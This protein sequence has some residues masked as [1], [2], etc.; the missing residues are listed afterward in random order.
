MAGGAGN[1]WRPDEYDQAFGFVADHG[2]AVL[3]LLGDV[4]GRSVLD[5]GC[6]TGHLTAAL[7]DRGASEVVGLDLSAAMLAAARRHYPALRF[8][9]GDAATMDLAELH[10]GHPFDAAFSNAALHW[11]PDLAAVCRSIHGVLASGGRFA[12]E[13]GGQGNIAAID[14]ALR[15][16]L[17]DVDLRDVE[18]PHQQFPTAAQQ[19]AL[20][21]SAGF[22]VRLLR[23]FERPTPLAPA[24]T[25]ASWTQHFRA[26]VWE[27]VPP[28]RHGDLAAAIDRR[29]TAAGLASGGW[30]IDY[31]RLQFV[32]EAR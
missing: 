15:Q 9:E 11:M 26:M 7:A 17:L 16:A 23:W 4:T 6:G 10:R 21:E 20:L 8:V 22:R 3:D 24:S 5:V 19:A 32:A 25:A 29:A 2:R 28:E 31:C 18:V 30:H 27:R 13:L 14:A 1:P 12:A